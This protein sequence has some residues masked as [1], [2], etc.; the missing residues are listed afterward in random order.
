MMDLKQRYALFQKH[1]K[2]F[3]NLEDSQEISHVIHYDDK[4]RGIVTFKTA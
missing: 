4:G 2:K 1:V 3:V